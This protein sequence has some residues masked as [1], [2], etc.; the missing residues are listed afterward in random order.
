[1]A[2]D[3]YL[4]KSQKL[5]SQRRKSGAVFLYPSDVHFITAR[6]GDAQNAGMAGSPGQDAA[7]LD[8]D[9]LGAVSGGNDLFKKI[10]GAFLA[11]T[12]KDE[13]IRFQIV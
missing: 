9:N 12:V 11:L 8:I 2:R 13:G 6:Q 7:I 10:V 1:M 3:L 5:Q 4:N